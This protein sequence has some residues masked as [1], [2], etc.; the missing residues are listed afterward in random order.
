MPPI[1]S[2]HRLGRG[3]PGY[4]IRFA[5][6][7]FAPQRQAGPSGAPSPPV[8]PPISTHFTA[9]PGIPPASAPLQPRR[10]RRHPPGEPGSFPPDQRGRLHALYA[11]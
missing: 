1:P 11:Q 5:P 4:L 7:A 6:H 9:P 3:L 2:T 8:F 10:L